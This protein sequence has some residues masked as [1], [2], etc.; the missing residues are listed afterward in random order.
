MF[1]F[2][3]G[4]LGIFSLAISFMLV[5]LTYSQ[6]RIQ[7]REFRPDLTVPKVAHHATVIEERDLDIDRQNIKGDEILFEISN[8][9]SGTA[10]QVR[11][12]SKLWML[13]EGDSAGTNVVNSSTDS[14]AGRPTAEP[15]QSQDE[16]KGISDGG[17]EN[18]SNRS[19]VSLSEF[20]TPRSLT[21]DVAREDVYHSDWT[22]TM[23]KTV[24]GDQSNT[25]YITRLHVQSEDRT[26]SLDEVLTHD[27]PE[28]SVLRLKVKLVYT[29]PIE[30]RDRFSRIIDS[31]IFPGICNNLEEAM[32]AE[33]PYARYERKSQTNAVLDARADVEH[34]RQ[35]EQD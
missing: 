4:S 17:Q 12:E 15:N 20:K 27:F 26:L 10:T 24:P 32:A 7:S 33:I 16:E 25:G 13:E 2:D 1:G 34:H 8:L 5:L 30:F 3:S 21:L 23:E 28:K 22:E 9:G 18:N 11:A 14:N 29:G 6:F 35:S 31:V 19:M